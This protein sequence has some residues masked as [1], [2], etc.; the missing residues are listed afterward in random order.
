[1]AGEDG[2]T[3]TVFIVDDDDDI[4]RSLTRG[5]EM[6]GYVVE[7]FASP[8]EFLQQVSPLRTGCLLLDYG[9]PGM[10][11]LELQ[12]KLNV[13]GSTLPIIFLTG[14][15]G[16]PESVQAIKAGALDFLEKPFRQSDLIERLEAAFQHLSERNARD[17][18][19]RNLRSRLAL[20]TAREREIAEWMLERPSEISSKEIAA[21]LKISPRT[22]DHHRAR[23]LEKLQIKSVAELIAFGAS[24]QG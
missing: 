9:M 18:H 19:S 11:G 10:N 20:L 12:Q 23:I 5:L 21:R 6:R 3:R 7:S 16:V 2:E 8:I 24:G 22:V 4:R 17:G 14:H 13:R 1:M 15:G